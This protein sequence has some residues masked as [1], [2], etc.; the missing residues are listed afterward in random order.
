MRTYEIILQ[1]L[2]NSEDGHTKSKRPRKT[3]DRAQQSGPSSFAPASPTSNLLAVPI[4]PDREDEKYQPE[5]I[6]EEACP[7]YNNFPINPEDLPNEDDLEMRSEDELERLRR[8]SVA[9][10]FTKAKELTENRLK[11]TLNVMKACRLLNFAYVANE[12]IDSIKEQCDK[13]LPYLS[14]VQKKRAHDLSKQTSM[15]IESIKFNAQKYK[16][17]AIAYKKEYDEN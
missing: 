4:A 13:F 11:P 15:I 9:V 17:A 3:T 7:L 16:N 10:T 5:S 2:N 6:Q 1:N 12:D 14:Y 8:E